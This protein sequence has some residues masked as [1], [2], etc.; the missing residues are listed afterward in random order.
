MGDMADML[1]D[2]MMDDPFE[3]EREDG[4][5]PAAW[6]KTCRCCKMEGLHWGRAEGKWRLFGMD[7]KIH[8]CAVRPLA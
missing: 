3:M 7:D 4:D 8:V 1:I 6:T 5:G 2:Q